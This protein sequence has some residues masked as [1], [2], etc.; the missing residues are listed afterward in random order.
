MK[1]TA[2]RLIDPLKACNVFSHLGYRH[3]MPD[4]MDL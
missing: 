1:P 2:N 4:K 3:I